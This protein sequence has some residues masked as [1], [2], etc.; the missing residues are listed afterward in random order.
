MARRRVYNTVRTD[1][2]ES[3]IAHYDAKGDFTA[4]NALRRL[5]KS[6]GAPLDHEWIGRET[7]KRRANYY[8]D[9]NAWVEPS[10][11]AVRECVAYAL[12][13]ARWAGWRFKSA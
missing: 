8:A 1:K 6:V 3:E 2:L 9:T 10:E 12:E 11:R 7:A 4:A 5:A 13:Q